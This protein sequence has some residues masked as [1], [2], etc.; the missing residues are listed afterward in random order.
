MEES[1]GASLI[2]EDPP[3][4][5]EETI[6]VNSFHIENFPQD[7]HIVWE[8]ENKRPRARVQETSGRRANGLD[9]VAA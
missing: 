5:R 7:C 3:T 1:E 4:E 2:Q 6:T 9:R 8:E